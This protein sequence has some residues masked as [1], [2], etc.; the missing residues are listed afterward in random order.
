MKTA[1][2]Y[3]LLT[4]T[5]QFNDENSD[6]S[7]AGHS[8]APASG[9]WH[10][11]LEPIHHGVRIEA[12][13]IEPGVT[14]ER[15]NLLAVVR[16]IE[17]LDQPSH[18]TLI[19][20][21]KYVGRGIRRDIRVWK[22]NQWQ[23]DR[24]GQRVKIKHFDLWQRIDR[25]MKFHK[26]DCRIFGSGNRSRLKRATEQLKDLSLV[27]DHVSPYAAPFAAP[28][29]A[30]MADEASHRQYD[31]YDLRRSHTKSGFTE[32]STTLSNARVKTAKNQAVV[33]NNNHRRRIVL[34][35]ERMND[36]YLALDDVEALETR[37]QKLFKATKTGW[38]RVTE[39]D[40]DTPLNQETAVAFGC[41]VN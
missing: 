36:S 11:V 8:L 35:N 10:F 27:H 3:L 14:G 34:T 20:P 18:V 21:S 22:E 37:H 17:A 1:P 39:I 12:D 13:D 9:R 7:T 25:A 31:D 23:W 26:I 2:H 30:P 29:A 19:T 38:T 4:D 24:F 40:A 15:L 5:D 33:P 41:S 16:G 28:M 6:T 32:S